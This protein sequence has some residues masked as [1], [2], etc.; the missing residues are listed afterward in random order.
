MTRQIR[1]VAAAMFVLFAALF[2]NLNYLQVI[3]AESLAQDTRNSRGLVR[4]YATRRGPIIAQGPPAQGQAAEVQIARVE[5]TDG[6]LRFLRR[7]DRGPLYAHVTGFH[8]V[9]YGRTELEES[10]N[11]YLVGS[12]PETFARN[13]GD[14]LAGRERQGDTVITTLRQP[15]QEAAQQA[16]GELRGAVVA[17]DPGTGDILALYSSPSYDPNELSSHDVAAVQA[18][19]ERLNA[20]P[21]GPLRNRAVRETYPPGSTFKVITAAAA[22][23]S[24]LSPDEAFPDPR[25]YDVPQTTADIGNFGG[26]LCNGGNPLTLTRALEVSCNTT[27]A[28]LG[29]RLGADALIAQAEAFGFNKEFDFGLPRLEPSR[30]P[31]ELDVPSTA[32]SAIGQRDVRA[33]PLQMAMV[34]GAI[35]FDGVLMSPR[36]VTQVEDV[37]GRIIRQFP[38]E[39]LRLTGRNDAQAV[40]S[41]TA[42]TLTDMMVGVVERGSG[43]RAQIPGVRVAG[44]TGTAEVGG[45]RQPTVWF[46]GFAPADQ[47]R[48]AVAVVIE[49]GGGVGDEATG[50]RLAA[51]VARQVMDAALAAG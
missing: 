50:G 7:Y 35:A 10:F 14:L 42:A 46:I 33:T 23:E 11:E 47:P 18:A 51:P 15:V 48:I 3:Q 34:A 27:F 4:E 24:G 41:Q 21:A 17:L 16:L 5:E 29:V 26:G 12:A 20:D 30:I 1:R 6:R 9:V 31:K 49:D 28:D 8:S 22:L 25:T 43:T 2:I 39:P 45:D 13:L 36:I 37:A 40:S 32:Q 44:K 19:Y 38:P